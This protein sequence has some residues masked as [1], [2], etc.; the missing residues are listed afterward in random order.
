LIDFERRPLMMNRFDKTFFFTSRLI[1]LILLVSVQYLFGQNPNDIFLQNGSFEGTPTCC[2]PPSGWTD[3]GFKGETPPDIQP[4]LNS[5]NKPFFNVTKK[6]I[7]GNTYLGMVV[8]ENETYERVSQRLITPLKKDLCYTF[9]IM[10]CR[11]ETYLSAS[12]RTE[13]NN[14]KQFT[15]PVILRIWGGEAYCNQ[16][17]F[18][19]ESP[20]IENTDRKKYEC[21]FQPKS[22]MNYFELEAFYKT[23]VLFPYNGNI[24]L[25]DASHITV[26]P[27]P[28]DS[29]LYKKYKKEKEKLNKKQE[30]AT[31]SKQKENNKNQNG[32]AAKNETTKPKERVFKYLDNSKV[33]VGQVFKIEKLYFETDSA[34]IK[35]ES[36]ASLEELRDYL[37]KFK[38]IRIEIGGHT[39]NKCSEKYCERLSL[40]RAE[41][42]KEYLIKQGIDP[43]RINTKGYGGK[44]PVASNS[45]AEGR[46]LN[47][48][49]EIKI[50][51]I[52][53]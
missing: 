22:D 30:Q 26:I 41:A 45:T 18:L 25:D 10:L 3:C 46:R 49:V 4:A 52:A 34:T 50:L 12:N 29:A 40:N 47:Q 24:L 16:K 21:K 5:D 23:P 39:N 7:A 31:A 35:Q 28:A 37:I 51:S 42:V 19:S 8:R 15:S 44:N 36:Q 11:S 53:G 32:T 17:Q 2:Q 9:S 27:C 33:A 43:K 1:V 6:A 14:L 48:R 13:P 38:K 20:I